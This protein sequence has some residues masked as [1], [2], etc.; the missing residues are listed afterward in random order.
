MARRGLGLLLIA[1][2]LLVGQL[3]WASAQ[4]EIQAATGEGK[5]VFIV[6]TQQGAQGFEQAK[7][8][9][10][11]AHALA[12]KTAVVVLDRGLPENRELVRHYS[13]AYA[14]VPT[15]F[16]MASNGIIG[17]AARPQGLTPEKLVQLIPTPKKAQVLWHRAQKMPVIVIASHA[18]M[19]Q[20]S[21]VFEAASAAVQK[22]RG[23]AT[24]VT[25]DMVKEGEVEKVFL[26]EL[27]VNPKE[28][29][30]TVVV[31]NNKGQKTA[32]FRRM[33]T[34]EELARACLMKAPCCP[35]GDC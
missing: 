20:Q 7:S 23:K 27:R 30:P 25:I 5:A 28:A 2:L 16:V 12:P 18:R 35:D 22:L 1:G 26:Q 34:A 11:Q 31:Y 29:V 14:P 4:T 17:A 13:L 32:V 19:A 6:L 15:I 8:I 10:D 3:A 21:A 33:V 24:T 9:A